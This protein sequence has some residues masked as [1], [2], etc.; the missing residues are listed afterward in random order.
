MRV[1]R[2]QT[3]MHT[4]SIWQS[5]DVQQRLGTT[6]KSHHVRSQP[7]RRFTEDSNQPSHPRSLISHRYLHEEYMHPWLSKMRPQKICSLISIFAWRICPI[8]HLP[9]QINISNIVEYFKLIKLRS[10]ANFWAFVVCLSVSVYDF[11][12]LS[13]ITRQNMEIIVKI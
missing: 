4:H 7:L 1:C 5:I 9:G 8:F 12:S 13:L 10:C 3:R 6:E 2:Q 11:L